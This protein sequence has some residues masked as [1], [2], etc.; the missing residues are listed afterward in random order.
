MA[1]RNTVAAD[2]RRFVARPSDRDPE[3]YF[4]PANRGNSLLNQP[5]ETRRPVFTR[6]TDSVTPRSDVSTPAR[7]VV[8][9]RNTKNQQLKQEPS[10]LD[11]FARSTPPEGVPIIT[12]GVNIW[13]KKN[14]RERFLLESVTFPHPTSDC[15]I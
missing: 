2:S 14:K 1:V 11:D 6:S 12:D 9:I 10:D 13:L 8:V 3:P 4:V 7:R 5:S 15:S